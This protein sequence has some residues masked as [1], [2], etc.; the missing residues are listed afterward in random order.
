MKGLHLTLAE[1]LPNV[2]ISWCA[3]HKWE[4][5]KKEW[6]GEERRR[7]FW[8]VARAS[9][10]KN[11][12]TSTAG[13]GKS[14]KACD[15]T[16]VGIRSQSSVNAGPSVTPTTTG[17]R[18][19]TISTSGRRPTSATSSVV[20]ATTTSTS[21]ERPTNAS[22]S[23]VRVATAS[24]S[25]ERPTNASSSGV[26]TATTPFGTQ[27]STYSATGQKRKTSTT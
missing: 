23:G 14:D 6:R 15:F 3:R 8:H 13:T 21:S 22:S 12:R 18:P 2:E 5:C 25:S 19:A 27:Q 9:I 17:V 4:K 11:V 24:T 7:K 26:R 10:E 1:L 16:N 20:R